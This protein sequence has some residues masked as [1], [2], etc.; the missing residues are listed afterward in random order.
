[1]TF[2][3][4]CFCGR[5]VQTNN[6]AVNPDSEDFWENEIYCTKACARNDALRALTARQTMDALGSP[7]LEVTEEELRF[8][9]HFRRVNRPK[10]ANKG[11]LPGPMIVRNLLNDSASTL[12][13]SSSSHGVC[14]D[15]PTGSSTPT[16]STSSSSLY[17]INKPLPELPAPPSI[18][19]TGPTPLRRNLS[20]RYPPINPPVPPLQHVRTAPPAPSLHNRNSSL[21]SFADST[22]FTSH[23]ASTRATSVASTSYASDDK[24]DL[25]RQ[26]STSS[27]NGRLCGVLEEDETLTETGMSPLASGLPYLGGQSPKADAHKAS[28]SSVTSGNPWAEKGGRPRQPSIHVRPATARTETEDNESQFDPFELDQLLLRTPRVRDHQGGKATPNPGSPSTPD[29][30][31]LDKVRRLATSAAVKISPLKLARKSPQA[32]DTTRDSASRPLLDLGSRVPTNASCWSLVDSAK[33]MPPNVF[34]QPG[35]PGQ[36]PTTPSLSPLVS[37]PSTSPEKGPLLNDDTT[38]VPK[39]TLV[40]NPIRSKPLFTLHRRRQP[41]ATRIPAQP[42]V[43][44]QLTLGPLAPSALGEDS[45]QAPHNPSERHMNDLPITPIDP[46]EEATGYFDGN[47]VVGPGKPLFLEPVAGLG[48]DIPEEEGCGGQEYGVVHTTADRLPEP[49]NNNITE[50]ENRA[51]TGT[52]MDQLRRAVTVHSSNPSGASPEDELLNYYFGDVDTGNG[53]VVDVAN[54]GRSGS[55]KTRRT[56]HK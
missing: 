43:S 37:T 45:L 15:S 40:R 11:V 14:R 1:M 36:F 16:S 19:P 34:H 2:Q 25:A 32:V 39:A 54:A 8:F 18:L 52:F 48:F 53:R 28:E 42:D 21:T 41:F 3:G 33:L 9:T 20:S 55:S 5:P 31:A 6:P 12:D 26:A 46:D 29:N 47:P 23:T 10:G 30:R 38:L 50:E 56:F 7:R 27:R 49:V 24:H 17:H 35:T 44:S 13:S 22:R 4:R 51:H